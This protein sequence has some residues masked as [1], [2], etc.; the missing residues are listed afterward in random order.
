MFTLRG[1]TEASRVFL[2]GTFNMW[3]EKELAMTRK[4]G[5][6]ELPYVLAQG[7]YEYKFIVDGE[8]ITDPSN[9]YIIR[10]GDIHNSIIAIEP[11]HTFTYP[12]S[13]SIEEVIVSGSF[14]G[15]SYENNLMVKKG[16]KWV[17]PMYLKPG[18]HLY[19]FVVDGEWRLDPENPAYEEN[20]F[21]TGNSVLWIEPPGLK[22]ESF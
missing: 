4:A 6:W 5:G 16:K 21:G 11:N 3:N 10:H 14:T 15:W 1:F 17:F 9:P 2:S 22:Q 19:K 13:A 18:K 12:D 8:W 7:N 20:E